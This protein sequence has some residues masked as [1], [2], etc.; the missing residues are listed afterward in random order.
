[1]KPSRLLGGVA[2]ALFLASCLLA[3]APAY[4]AREK[5]WKGRLAP[6]YEADLTLLSQDRAPIPASAIRGV[7][8]LRT[9][10]GGQWVHASEVPTP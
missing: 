2:V 4:A 10:I 7:Q 5:G 9:M 6:G 3:I 8:V 1:M